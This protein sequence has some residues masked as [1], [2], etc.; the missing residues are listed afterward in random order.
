M[1]ALPGFS[2]GPQLN[3]RR[4]EGQV[5]GRRAA[6]VLDPAAVPRHE[7]LDLLRREALGHHD[8]Y[9]AVAIHPHAGPSCPAAA[10]YVPARLCGALVPK[11]Q[12]L[13]GCSNHA[14]HHNRAQQAIVLCTLRGV[15]TLIDIGINLTHSSFDRDRAAVVEAA[16]ASGVAQLIVTGTTLESSRAAAELARA[17]PGRL[18]ATAGVHPHHASE[19][20][21]SQLAELRALLAAPG[22]VAA[23]ECGLDYYRNYSPP[24]EQ[25]VAFARQL[26]LS[27]DCGRPLF[28]HQREAHADFVAALREH[29]RSV[30]GVAHC[31]TG[32]EAE[33]DAYLE[34]G[35]HIGITG[36]VCD[37]RRGQSLQSLV[38]RIPAGRLLLETDA[39]YLLPRDLKERVVARRNEPRFL[40]HIAATVARL[41][42]ETLE[43]CSAHTTAAAR[44][45]FGLAELA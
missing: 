29:G 23:G 14:S 11:R 16:R 26:R 7:R 43:Q 33:L 13:Q 42:D 36:W 32:G 39:P 38:A 25:R 24:A 34:L 27:A 44:S 40:P 37:E 22:V 35:L 2:Q 28:L 31:Y 12:L 17:H 19:L 18:Y 45:L 6:M 4:R 21:E 9:G 3:L 41:R 8:L 1:Q 30:R 5:S 15:M 20:A 10:P